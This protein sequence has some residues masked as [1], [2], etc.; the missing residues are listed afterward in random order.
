MTKE[1]D[2]LVLEKGDIVT[3]ENSNMLIIKY[4][5]YMA[6]IIQRVCCSW[7]KIVRIERPHYETI[8]EASKE[9]LTK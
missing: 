9:I 4:E 2:K 8:Y 1:L 7:G 5:T 3:F 6:D